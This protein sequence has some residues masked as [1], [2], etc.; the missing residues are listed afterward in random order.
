MNATYTIRQ[1]TAAVELESFKARA[2]ELT[3]ATKVTLML[4]AAPLLGL[5]FILALPIVGL[6]VVV[7]MSVK[8]LIRHRA[9]VAGHVKRIVLFVAAP[10]IALFY[11]AAFPFFA[12]GMLVYTGIRAA[13]S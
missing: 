3:G 13:R 11:I 9:V 7:W 10:F 2:R 5:A 12:L 8:A 4:A 1:E 6:A